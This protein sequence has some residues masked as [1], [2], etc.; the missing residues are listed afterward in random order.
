MLCKTFK[1]HADLK[2]KKKNLEET[3]YFHHSLNTVQILSWLCW[4]ISADGKYCT[5]KIL[6]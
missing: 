2:Q 3:D 1:I 6:L 5:L 4:T